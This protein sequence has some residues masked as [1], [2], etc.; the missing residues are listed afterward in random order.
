MDTQM[1]A[2]L[3]VPYFQFYILKN[4]PRAVQLF[5]FCRFLRYH[6]AGLCKL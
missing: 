3:P 5:H 4:V 6:H 2:S 1:C